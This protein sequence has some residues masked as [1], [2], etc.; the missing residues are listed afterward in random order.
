MDVAARIEIEKKIVRH[1]IRTMK[2]HGWDAHAVNDGEEFHIGLT[3]EK[4][5]M[6]HAFAVDEASIHFENKKL[7][8]IN[9]EGEEKCVSHY[10]YLV[11]GNDGYDVIADWSYRDDDNFKIIMEEIIEPYAD[12][13]A[14]EVL[15]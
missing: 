5:V 12:A 8:F 6:D 10:V 15:G 9:S 4:Q 1:L 14:D 11:F 7:P 2:E 3:A 13:I